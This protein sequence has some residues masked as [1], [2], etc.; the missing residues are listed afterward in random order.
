VTTP[1][2]PPP[3]FD[4]AKPLPLQLELPAAKAVPARAEAG[5]APVRAAASANRRRWLARALVTLIAV[6]ALVFVVVSWVLPWYVRRECIDE[7]A[8]HGIDLAVDSAQIDTSGFHLIGVRASFE[9]VPGMHATVPEVRV[10][11]S[12]LRP[13]SLSM[14]GAEL[15]LAG[16]VGSVANAF[17]RWR[18]SPAGGESGAWV[19]A[20][21]AIEGSRIVWP[22]AIGENARVEA[23]D[24]NVQVAW[25]L[26]EPEI[27]FRS[28]RV[29]V[30]V[31]GGSLGPWRA[32]I[33]RIPPGAFASDRTPVPAS[34]RL[35]LALDPGVPDASTVL[36]VADEE[37]TTSVDIVVPRSPLGRLGVP[38]SLLGLHGKELQVD[39][40]AH[41]GASGPKH[42]DGSTKGGIYGIEAPG[43][44]R[45]LDV[46]W[47]VVASGAPD[48]GLDVKT[49]RLAAGPLV[50]ALT[51]MLK[52]FD[53]G[54]RV[55]LAWKA[56]P[57]PCKAF[58]TPLASSG[59]FDIAYQLRKLAEATGLTRIDGDVSARASLAFDSRDVG[60]TRFDFAPDAK[61]QVALFAP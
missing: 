9:A 16:A 12:G 28:E 49:G 37:R 10:H 57:V 54:F 39:I 3:P 47:D 15:T 55:D 46:A 24:V 14:R 52:T 6:G 13:Q 23:S 50:G 25:R 53:D 32:D 2:E 7:A 56:G 27:H 38:P 5:L 36:A 26:R 41:Y 48:T 11:T 22:G 20:S 29:I 1:S 17:A 59:P 34:T 45:S 51:G 21:L 35:R 42:A 44:P 31:P 18:A 58:D 33:D 19:P 60:A 61:C 30:A 8:A 4:P 40:T 43:I